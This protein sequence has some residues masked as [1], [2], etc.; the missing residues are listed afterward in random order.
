VVEETGVKLM[1]GFNR[2]F[3]PSFREARAQ[4]E[5][6]KVG[7]P[8]LLKITSRD[9]GPPPPE[10]ISVSGG[11]FLDMTIHDF[12]MA[13]FIVGSDVVEVFAKADV[14]IDQQIGD[15][16]DVDTAVI[17][18]TFK[19]GCLGVIDNS[20][21]TSYGYDQR[22]EIF[23]SGGM[24]QVD[25]CRHDTHQLSDATGTHQA[26]LLD[27]FMDRYIE[28]YASEMKAFIRAVAGEIQLPVSGEDGLLS[29]AIGLA[30]KKSVAENRPVKLA[31]ILV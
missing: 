6:G 19:N 7:E 2:R 27:F 23:G 21:K 13:R 5:S 30:A 16:G 20:R 17:L 8:H 12:D 26:L 1:V 11:L 15:L 28:S 4:V 29:V 10:Y 24:V 14:L 18:L 31:E 9:P 22:L 25:N 3:D